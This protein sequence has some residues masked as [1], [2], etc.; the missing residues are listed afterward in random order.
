ME[1][2]S[3]LL[4]LLPVFHLARNRGLLKELL[5]EQGVTG[6]KEGRLKRNNFRYT[7]EDLG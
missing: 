6:Y 2:W 3:F 5:V 1:A 4:N 7:P